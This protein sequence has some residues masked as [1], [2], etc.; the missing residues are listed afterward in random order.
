MRTCELLSWVGLGP[1]CRVA[2]VLRDVCCERKGES[3]P[4]NKATRLLAIV[5][6]LQ[7]RPCTTRELAERFN[8]SERTIQQDLAD[9]RGDPLHVQ[10]VQYMRAEW[11]LLQKESR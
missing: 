10:L 1:A 7:E 8:V 4:V 3:E 9:L 6:A 11:G 2:G 5:Q